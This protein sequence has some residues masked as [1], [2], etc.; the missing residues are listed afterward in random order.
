M[1]HPRLRFAILATGLLVLASAGMAKAD[2][3]DPPLIDFIMGPNAL[4]EKPFAKGEYKNVRKMFAAYFEAKHGPAL[5][6]NLGDDGAPLFEFLNANPEIKETLFTAIDPD[7]D[8]PAQAMAVFRDLWKTDPA[9][10]KANDELA[11]AIAVVWDNPRGVYDYRGHQIRTK[12]LLPDTVAK[13]DALDNFKYVLDRQS[14]LKGPQLQLPWEFLVHTVNHKTPDNE[15]DWA[16]ERYL[17]KRPGIGTIYKEIEYDQEMLRTKSKVCKLNDKPYTLESIKQYGGVCAMQ[18]DFAARVAKS[19]GVPAEYVGGESNSGGLHAWVMWVEVK[20]INKDA[21]AFTLE[22]FGRY[23]GDQYYVGTLLDPKSGKK[24]TDREMER[25]LTAVGA[26]PHNSRQAD[27]LMRAFP[28]VRDA[29]NLTT[30]QQLAYLNKVLALFPMSDAAWVELAALHRDGK[31]TDSVEATRLVDK[32][33]TT[34]AKFPDFTAQ[35]VGDLLT[36]Q[37][38]KI[39][40]TRTF[41]KMATAFEVLGRPDLACEARLQLVDYQADAKDY[42]KAFDGLANTVRKFPDEGRYVPRLITRMQEVSKDMKGGDALMAKFY[43]EILPRVPPR[44][45]NEVSEYCVKLHKQAVAYL[46]DNNK[47]KEAAAVEQSLA[48]VSGGKTP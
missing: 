29:R 26:A 34:F 5:K 11:I 27:L 44:R 9:A 38:D 12:S 21:V 6:K 46:K 42:K 25:H 2:D 13:V 17:K 40:R 16:V 32:A 10:V 4:N 41:E 30:K 43:L 18:A 24:I 35:I 47:P 1:H 22:S 31:L 36:A 39:Y 33:L 37:K 28:V 23:F 20:S 48:R 19:L 14:K 45:G 7:T 15:R 3:A 8:N